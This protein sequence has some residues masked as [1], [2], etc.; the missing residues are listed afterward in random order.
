MNINITV[1]SFLRFFQEVFRQFFFN[2]SPQ[3]AAGLAY[4]TLLAAV[5]LFAVIVGFG[6]N[7]VQRDTVQRFLAE[8]LL[9][10]RQDAIMTAIREFAE[11]SNRFGAMGLLLFLITVINLLNN[12]EIHLSSLCR[13][14]TE[15]P[16]LTRF[17]TYTAVL[18]LSGLLIG[19]SITLSGSLFNH[20]LELYGRAPISTRFIRQLSSF[21]FIFLSLLLLIL[22]MPSGKIRFVSALTGASCASILWEIAKRLFSTWANQSVRISV[23]YGSLFLLPLLLIWLYVVWLI[24]LFSVEITYIH[25]HRDF[26]FERDTRYTPPGIILKNGLHLYA[27]IADYFT[28]RKNPPGIHEL[29]AELNLSQQEVEELLD[30]LLEEKLIHR[31]RVTARQEGYIPAAPPER[32]PLQ[33]L[34][35]VLM[36]GSKNT[37]G[38][39]QAW[40]KIPAA[41]DLEDRLKKEMEGKTAGEFLKKNE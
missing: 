4:S 8:T 37:A 27:L 19:A 2:K 23:I 18:V 10:T 5:P 15:K 30:P 17:T 3:R 22:L 32:L 16:L 39:G 12:I 41:R 13:I 38:G 7:L 29:A 25:Q 28:A 24:I 36:Y 31:V 26:I 21:L 14:R 1:R 33:E 9:P 20:L 11:N 40:T 35:R 34:Y 6:G